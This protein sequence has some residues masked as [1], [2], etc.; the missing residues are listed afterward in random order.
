[1]CDIPMKKLGIFL[2]D[3][4]EMYDTWVKSVF[5]SKDSDDIHAFDVTLMSFGLQMDSIFSDINVLSEDDEDAVD[6][7]GSIEFF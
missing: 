2:G 1:M 4:F 3:F 5:V 6:E 7:G